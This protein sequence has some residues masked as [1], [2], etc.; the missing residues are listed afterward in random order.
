MARQA[1]IYDVMIASPGDVAIERQIAREVVHEW[2]AVHGATSDV[3]LNAVGW[4]THSSPSM[5]EHP[6]EIINKQI[7]Q[8]SDLVIAI[9]W[10]RLGTPTGAAA[11]G[12]VNEMQEHVSAGKPALLYFSATPVQPASIDAEQFAALQTFKSECMK[13]G[14]VETYESISEF[15]E[16]L[17]RQLAQTV[18]RSFAGAKADAATE[19]HT[20]V[21]QQTPTMSAEATQLLINIA[22]DSNGRL[23]KI[24]TLQGMIIQTNGKNFCETGNARSEAAWEGA[25]E[26]LRSLAL[27]QDRGHRGEVFSLTN[28]GF[29]LADALRDKR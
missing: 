12:T 26:E 22:Q 18:L 13:Q 1:T 29:R 27:L 25:I 16:K 10:T 8:H 23:M 15:R 4:E 21:S 5:G 9:F 3:F 11:S 28:E 14:L 19:P 7:L 6:Q 2:N 24:G 17:T 20:S